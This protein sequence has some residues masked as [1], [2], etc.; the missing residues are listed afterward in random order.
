MASLSAA[1]TAYLKLGFTMFIWG[2]AWPVGKFLVTGLPPI[3]VA[4]IR[5]LIVVLALFLVMQWREGSVRIPRAW[6]GTFIFLGLLSVT[7]YQAFFLFGVKYAASSDDSLVIGLSPLMVAVL[8]SFVVKEKLT[9]QKVAGLILGL[10][11]VALIWELSP[12][13]NVPNRALGMGLI[14]GGVVVY[15]MYTVY[16]RKFITTHNSAS[17][18]EKPPSPLAIITWVS[19]LGWLFLIPFSLLEAPWT[20]NWDALAWLGIFYLALLSTVIGYLFYVQGVSEIGAT[21]AVI[22]A[23]LV[24]VFGALSSALILNEVLSVWHAASIAL[25]FA[26]V[27]LVNRRL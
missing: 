6:I 18:S 16:L 11:G 1:W 26:G 2:V 24:P 22:F 3:S 10:A 17:H 19:F 14:V 20:Y 27:Y 4:M 7:V 23:N 5:Y 25:I 13:T 9:W 15:A 21:R 12:N 8:A